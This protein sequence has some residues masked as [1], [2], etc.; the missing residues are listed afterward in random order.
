[1]DRHLGA[2]DDLERT[3]DPSEQAR[4]SEFGRLQ[5][6][7]QY[8]LGRGVLRTILACYLRASPAELVFRYTPL[9]KPE[10]ENAELYFSLSHSGDLILYAFS[11][12]HSVGVDAERVVP[13]VDQEISRHFLRRS[14]NRLEALPSE[15]RRQTF[16][17]AWT[18]MEAFSKTSGRGAEPDLRDLDEFLDPLPVREPRPCGTSSPDNLWTYDLRP[19]E[20]YVAALV[21]PGNCELKCWRWLAQN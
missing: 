18:R 11:S 4:A 8:V 2:F 17:R 1:V 3:H 16:Y 21:G 10:L 15:E 5:E 14:M 13:G 9:G 20:D 6:R 12:T 19:R 7:I